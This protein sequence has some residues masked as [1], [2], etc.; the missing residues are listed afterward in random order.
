MQDSSNTASFSCN[1]QQM[2]HPSR[3]TRPTCRTSLLRRSASPLHGRHT[4]VR[5]SASPSRLL[6]L[7]ATAGM[8]PAPGVAEFQKQAT[9]FLGHRPRL[10][11]FPLVAAKV[12]QRGMLV[13]EMSRSL[14]MRLQCLIV[15][16]PAL[17]VRSHLSKIVSFL[18][19]LRTPVLPAGHRRGSHCT[20]MNQILTQSRIKGFYVADSLR[21]AL[22]F[23]GVLHL[24]VHHPIG[25][26]KME[27]RTPNGGKQCL[28]F[29]FF[30]PILW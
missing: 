4:T 2:R 23:Q 13:R 9:L 8:L 25:F 29:G 5:R 21:N 15:G 17:P 3:A 26:F 24:D 12:I 22:V 1:F 11:P 14:H 30:L 6:S 19:H 7:P 27:L 10:Y 16:H 20:G 18:P 28:L